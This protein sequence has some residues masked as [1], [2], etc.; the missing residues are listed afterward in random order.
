MHVV[1][2]Y[3]GR[4]NTHAYKIKKR[5]E[6]GKNAQNPFP[7]TGAAQL[8]WLPRPL[9]SDMRSQLRKRPVVVRFGSQAQGA[10]HCAWVYFGS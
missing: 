9:Q 8:P 6:S 4:Q 3:M 5:G 1:H 2:R 7:S 10:A